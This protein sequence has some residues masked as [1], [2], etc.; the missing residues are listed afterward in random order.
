MSRNNSDSSKL[1]P[2]YKKILYTEEQVQARVSEMA[3]E[4]LET[5]GDVDP[6]IFV[7]ILNGAQPFSV[8]FVRAIARL[9]PYFHPNLQSMIIS[10]Y[11]PDREPGEPRVITDLPPDYRNLEGYSAFI[12]E[13]LIDGGGTIDCATKHLRGYG[14][15]PVKSIVFVDKVKYPPIKTPIAMYGFKVPDVWVTGYG[16]DDARIKKEA[17]RQMGHIAI[18]NQD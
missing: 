3:E 14:A 7:S 1:K 9:D 13:D 17:N 12:L 18:A 16:M 6:I 10:R 8:D 11:G 15:N 2:L 5:Y 4:F